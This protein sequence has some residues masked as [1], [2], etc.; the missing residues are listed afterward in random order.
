VEG[1]AVLPE[2]P[3]PTKSKAPTSSA[4][5]INRFMSRIKRDKVEYE[6]SIPPFKRAN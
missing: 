2:Q 3:A 4:R 6:H 1:F 5:G